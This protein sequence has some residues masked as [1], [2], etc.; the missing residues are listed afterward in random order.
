MFPKAEQK[1]SN[2]FMSKLILKLNVT[3]LGS[4]RLRH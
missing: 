3:G 1:E 4:K 2:T